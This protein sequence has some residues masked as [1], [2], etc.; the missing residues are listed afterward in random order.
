MTVSVTLECCNRIPQTGRL[1]NNRNLFLTALEAGK[2][3][4]S[5]PGWSGS[6]ETTILSGLQTTD[7]SLCPH[8]VE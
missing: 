6:G 1:I 4:I 5:V 2:S 8:I 3:K 7:F